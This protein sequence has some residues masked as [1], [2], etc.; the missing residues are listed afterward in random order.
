MKNKKGFTLIELLCVLALISIITTLAAVKFL[1]FIASENKNTLCA[2]IAMI[3]NAS[4]DYAV[5]YEKEL[6]NSTEYFNGYKSIKLKI[7]DLVINKVIA[8]DQDN[9]VINPLDKSSINDW[10]VIFYLE[11]NKDRKS[12]V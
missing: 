3:K 7:N 9:L 1:P 8:A 4:L 5:K 10:D 12:V 6:N 2:K 11:N